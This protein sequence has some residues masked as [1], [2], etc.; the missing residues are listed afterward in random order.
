MITQSIW[1]SEANNTD[2][3]KNVMIIEAITKA[4]ASARYSEWPETECCIEFICMVSVLLYF[5]W[6]FTYMY[7]VTPGR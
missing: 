5:Y 1:L 6:Y 2:N 3:S 7:L 4:N